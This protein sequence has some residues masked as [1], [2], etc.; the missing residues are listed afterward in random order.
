VFAPILNIVTP[1]ATRCKELRRHHPAWKKAGGKRFRLA[2]DQ[3]GETGEGF[4]R[5]SHR[6]VILSLA[7]C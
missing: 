6:I 4:K 3:T 1:Q 2:E 5:A 7:G